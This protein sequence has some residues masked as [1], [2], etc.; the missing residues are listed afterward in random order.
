ML[1]GGNATSKVRLRFLDVNM[2][3]TCKVQLMYLDV[4]MQQVRYTWC[5]YR[6]KSDKKGTTNLFR[7]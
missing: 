6:L 2:K 4:K 5:I 3:E 1:I 7:G